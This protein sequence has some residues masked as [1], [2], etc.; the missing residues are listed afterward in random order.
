MTNVVTCYLLLGTLTVMCAGML[1]ST[2]LLRH[3]FSGCGDGD[4]G[5]NISINSSRGSSSS[6]SKKCLC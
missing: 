5:S 1:Y 3:Y 4:G 6:N 2:L